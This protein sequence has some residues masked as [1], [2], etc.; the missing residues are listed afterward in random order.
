MEMKKKRMPSTQPAPAITKI[1]FDIGCPPRVAS[2]TQST[3]QPPRKRSAPRTS[4]TTRRLVGFAPSFLSDF[5]MSMTWR[6][7]KLSGYCC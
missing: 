7:S 6:I 3:I 2:A 4:M 1:V 5:I